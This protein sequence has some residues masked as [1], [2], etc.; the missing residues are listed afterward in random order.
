MT[1]RRIPP[2]NPDVLQSAAYK[3][4]AGDTCQSKI[5]SGGVIKRD[6]SCSDKNQRKRPDKFGGQRFNTQYD[7][8]G[9]LIYN[10]SGWTEL[11]YL[12]DFASFV[13]TNEAVTAI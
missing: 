2:I 3:R 8:L 11:F 4:R 12:T 13:N 7:S 9:W 1:L 10:W 5:T 6:R